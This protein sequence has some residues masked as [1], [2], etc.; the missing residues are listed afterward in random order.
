MRMVFPTGLFPSLRAVCRL[1]QFLRSPYFTFFSILND[2]PY[3]VA[4]IITIIK[5]IIH[6]VTLK[7]GVLPLLP[8]S[9]SVAIHDHVG[10]FSDKD[11]ADVQQAD[12]IVLQNQPLPAQ[13]SRH[14]GFLHF[15]APLPQVG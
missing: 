13:E 4:N 8:E 2:T 6:V 11:K 9:A 12:D 1:C 7:A 10:R 15:L 14:V 3:P 5:V